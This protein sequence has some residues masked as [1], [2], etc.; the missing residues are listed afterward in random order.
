MNSTKVT[1]AKNGAEQQVA[2]QRTAA[3]SEG[4]HHERDGAHRDP[5]ERHHQEHLRDED[6]RDGDDR[7]RAPAGFVRERAA[8]KGCAT[9]AVPLAR[10][11][12]AIRYGN[13]RGPTVS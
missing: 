5:T 7:Q 9:I 6:G 11:P 2:Q 8:R 12:A 3:E 1:P 4:D 10:R 13:A